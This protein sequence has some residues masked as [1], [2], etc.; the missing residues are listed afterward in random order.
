M[1]PL[2][3]DDLWGDQKETNSEN[4]WIVAYAD[5]ITLLFVFFALLL[6]VSEISRTK[7]EVLSSQIQNKKASITSLK[8]ELDKL[9]QENSLEKEISTQLADKGLVIQFSETLLF[10]SASATL[11]SRGMTAIETLGGLLKEMNQNYE[12]SVEGHTDSR[13]I[14]TQ[15]FQS[16]WSLSAARSLTV[17]EFLIK[18]GVE[19]NKIQLKAF[20]DTQPISEVLE[21]NRRVN[22]VVY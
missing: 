22:I 1:K 5:P 11:A 15:K 21:K 4:A 10:D 13:P 3:Q 16:N 7:I 9:I 12:L 17:V 14:Q 2:Y 19:K 20:A 8:N 18:G 6:S